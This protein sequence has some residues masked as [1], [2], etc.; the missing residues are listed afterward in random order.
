MIA[1]QKNKVRALDV[2]LYFIRKG[3]DDNRP[4]TNKQLQ[5]LVYYAQ[6][7]SLVLN[8]EK[9]FSE[10]IEAWVHGPAI[11]SL[12]EKFKQFGAE[13]II[14]EFEGSQFIF[15]KKQKEVLDNVWRVY[16]KFDANY[17]EILVHSELPWQEARGELQ[18]FESSNNKISPKT[19]KSYY[20]EVL[21]KAQK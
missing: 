18:S 4:I 21:E 14:L 15:L 5:K 7:W 1:K 12:Y 3:L 19:M 17:L 2:A 9:L 11:P 8:E 10:R 20:S 16:G 13:P 6:A